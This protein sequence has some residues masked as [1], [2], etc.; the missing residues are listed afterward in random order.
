MLNFFLVLSLS[1]SAWATYFVSF[2][3]SSLVLF[4][5]TF[6][7]FLSSNFI[8]FL[9]AD[10]FSNKFFAN[11]K[12]SLPSIMCL[13]LSEVWELNF[14]CSSFLY[15]LIECNYYYW[16]KCIIC[17][18]DCSLSLFAA[19]LSIFCMFIR[20]FIFIFP[21]NVSIVNFLKVVLTS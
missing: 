20:L 21:T 8:L 4:L 17:W 13:C 15:S 2:F 9:L 18:N 19:D 10:S 6:N 16:R 12:D 14:L 5:I 11:L 1:F 7:W 3:I